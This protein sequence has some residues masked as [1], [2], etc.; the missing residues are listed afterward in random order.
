M[1]PDDWSARARLQLGPFQ[2]L[3]SSRKVISVHRIIGRIYGISIFVSVP[4]GIYLAVYATGGLASS[5]AF[6]ILDAAWFMTA[7]IGLKRI[8]EKKA[9]RHQEWML[10]SYAVTLVFVTFR[11]F[12]PLLTIAGLPLSL[13]FSLSVYLSMAVNLGWAEWYLWRKKGRSLK[14][15]ISA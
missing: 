1:L 5:I 2:F 11:V 3:Q 9:V 10:R 15:N 4:A 13:S 6:I 8:R 7:F 12:L 14:P